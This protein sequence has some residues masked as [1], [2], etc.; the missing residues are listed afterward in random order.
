MAN[1]V[2]MFDVLG[3]PESHPDRAIARKSIELL[4]VEH[5]DEIYCQPC[6]SPVW[7][8]GLAAQSL[9]EVGSAE[10]RKR[11]V[12]GLEWLKPK[13][14]LDVVILRKG[15]GRFGRRLP[16]GFDPL[17]PRNLL[18]FKSYWEPL[19]DWALQGTS[20]KRKKK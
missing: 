6:V 11:A 15:P 8:T 1:S 10:A 2:M 13:Q 19:D 3:Y 4:L 18:T 9:I 16:D 5:E 14:I 20:P 12:K 7:D 17:A